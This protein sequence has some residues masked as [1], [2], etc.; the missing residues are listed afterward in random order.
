MP[1]FLYIIAA[2]VAEILISLVGIFFVFLG[3]TQFRKYLPYFISF[4]VGTFLAVVFLELLPEAIEISTPETVFFYTL[5]GFLFFFLFSRVLHWYHHHDE[6]CHEHETIKASGYMILAGDLIHNFIDG[7]IITLAFFVDINVGALTTVAVL[8]HELPQ[9]VS[10]FFVLIN[11]GLSKT[12]A[13]FLNFLVSLTTLLGAVLT[14]FAAS[15]IEKIIGPALGIVAGNFLYIS[16]SDLIPELNLDH[17]NGSST[18][19]QFSLILLG[20]I[21]IY[22]VTSLVLE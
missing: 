10:D 6:H 14:Y 2:V 21:V 13:L 16:M 22:L 19:K 11:S 8:F 18:V 4:S 12:K 17:K 3:Y 15:N 9:E 1:I 20:I 5:I 7:I